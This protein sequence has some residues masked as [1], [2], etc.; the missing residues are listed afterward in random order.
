MGTVHW[1]GWQVDL[2]HGYDGDVPRCSKNKPSTADTSLKFSTAVLGSWE[3]TARQNK[4]PLS[5]TRAFCGATKQEVGGGSRT[6]RA[7][8]AG[9]S[10]DAASTLSQ[11]AEPGGTPAAARPEPS[12]Q[13]PAAPP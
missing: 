8:G 5:Y 7:A 10:Y 12:N 2:S 4:G 3:G 6:Y 13:K 9:P 11:E 1:V